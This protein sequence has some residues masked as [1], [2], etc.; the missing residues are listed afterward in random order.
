M[1]EVFK[2]STVSES[3][4]SSKCTKQAKVLQ[5]INEENEKIMQS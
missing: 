3:Q 1:L 5:Y 4:V 2:P